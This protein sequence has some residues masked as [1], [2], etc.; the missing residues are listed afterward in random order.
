MTYDYQQAGRYFAQAPDDIKEIVE[1]ELQALGG[2]NVSA[3]YRG[4]YFDATPA[5]LYAVNYRS[6]LV[7]RVLAPL[8]TFDCHSDKYLYKRA[9]EV[10]WEDFLDAS[11][12][13]AVFATVSNST[14]NHSQFAGLRLKDAIVDYFR[15]RNGNR[16]SINTQ[17]PDVWL[18]LHIEHNRAT[19]SVDTSG[20]SLHRRG[21]R[22]DAVSAPMME[23]LAA[24]VIRL[25]GWDGSVPLYDPMCGS[26]TFLCEAY[27]YASHKPPGFL[28]K[29]FGFERLPDFNAELWQ[30]VRLES[31]KA[32]VVPPQGLISG[33]DIQAES[34]E[35]A[36]R[37]LQRVDPERSI[38]VIRQDVFSMEEIHGR[39]IVCNPPYGL[40]MGRPEDMADFYRRLGDFLKQRC[41]GSTACVYFG[42]PEYLK[43]LGLKPKWKRAL[44][45]GGLD[46]VLGFYEL[47]EGYRRHKMRADYASS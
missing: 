34:V 20:G 27:L 11:Q 19:L 40:R 3:G 36:R 35:I 24:A 30:R 32:V 13:F 17:D 9:S 29:R 4:V 42:E 45:N 43:S 16:P 47:F 18:N 39:M 38:S 41:T 33:S 28:R 23:T 6:Q 31:E 8:T 25:S 21:Y 5:V 22:Q 15:S 7:S 14:I 46:G 26:G 12:T 10:K 2:T 1:A 44:S 37:N